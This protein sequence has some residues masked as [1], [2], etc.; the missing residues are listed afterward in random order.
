MQ[1][2]ERILV[3]FIKQKNQQK[4]QTKK[5]KENTYKR[6]NTKASSKVF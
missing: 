4:K 5:K 2:I 3:E 6:A 1:C